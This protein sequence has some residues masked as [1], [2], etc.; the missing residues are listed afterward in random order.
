METI[1]RASRPEP[2][3]AWALSLERR[4]LP[5]PRTR[6]RPVN[7]MRFAFA[8]GLAAVATSLSLAGVG[9]LAGG[10]GSVS[11]RDDCRMVSVLRTERVPSLATDADG[12]VTLVY[13]A[14]TVRRWMQRCSPPAPPRGAAGTG[15]E[16]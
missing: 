3:P 7:L 4:V 15:R 6:H 12:T 5:V 8:G 10:T 11:A 16:R 14:R 2:D 13:R 1:L 9:P